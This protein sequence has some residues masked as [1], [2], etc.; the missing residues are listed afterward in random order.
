MQSGAGCMS[1]AADQ[2]YG[3]PG[4]LPDTHVNLIKPLSQNLVEICY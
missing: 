2:M 1:C 4:Y 3:G